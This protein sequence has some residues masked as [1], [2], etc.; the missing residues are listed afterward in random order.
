MNVGSYWMSEAS[1]GTVNTLSRQIVMPIAAAFEKWKDAIGEKWLEKLH[2]HPYE[3]ATFIHSVYPR[4]Q[5][6]EG[7]PRST[8]KQY[9]SVIWDEDQGLIVR[10]S[11]FE[12]FPYIA[13]RW[14]K[15]TGE[16]WGRGPGHKAIGE[17]KTLCKLRELK[18]LGLGLDVAPPT[19]E[20]ESAVVGDLRWEP[21][22]RNVVRDDAGK[23]AVWT[24]T[25]GAR[26][27]V[28]QIEEQEMVQTI[29]KCFYVD[30][31]RSLPPTD[32]NSYMTAYEVAKRYEETFRLLGP[33]FGRMTSQ[34]EGLGHVV[35]RG[36]QALGR[37]K[38]LP[39]LPPELLERKDAEMDVEYL[40]PLALAQKSADV[41]ALDLELTALAQLEA[42]SPGIISHNYK[43]DDVAQYRARIRGIPAK[44]MTTQEE[45]DQMKQQEQEAKQKEE[46]LVRSAA[47]AKGMGDAAPAMKLMGGQ[48]GAQQSAP[49]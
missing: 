48:G 3:M 20:K 23:D 4:E 26:Y 27:D 7:N 18:L 47:A 45:R 24:L 31:I 19:F 6:E 12:D 30:Q 36:V 35:D 14:S 2:D 8:Q 13:G 11:G 10:E 38:M 44:L 37:A 42:V 34:G 33:P 39:P 16:V 1:D 22:G 41:N 28:T 17:V 46:A 5:W 32:H 21:L 15:A 49:A 9:A 43:M 25:T 40:G 29:E